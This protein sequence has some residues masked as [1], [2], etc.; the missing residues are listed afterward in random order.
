MGKALHRHLILTSARSDGFHTALR[1]LPW[2][3]TARMPRAVFFRLWPPGRRHRPPRRGVTSAREESRPPTRAARARTSEELITVTE[4]Q[5]QVTWLTQDAHDRLKAELDDLVAQ[6]PVIAQKIN[7]A[8][9]EGDLKEN[10]GYHAAREEQG[11]MEARIRHLQE[12]LHT[13]KVGETPTESGTAVPGTVLTVRFE[14]DD[15]T[16]TFLLGS[17]EEGAHGE[18]EV[19]SP[20]SPLGSALLGA[21]AGDTVSYDLPD[22]GSMQVTLISAEPYRP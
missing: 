2:G 21:K 22:G 3:D 10:G 14:G 17:R 12:L 13:A 4:T 6:R 20:N 15:D 7:A 9:E 16:E 18:L 19:Y 8:R 5:T 1:V 11:V